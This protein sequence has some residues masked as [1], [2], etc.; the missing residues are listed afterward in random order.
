M[1]DALQ[2]SI[3]SLDIGAWKVVWGPTVWKLDP[4]DTKSAADHIW[5]VASSTD[6][7]DGETATYVVAIAGLAANSG[8]D[9]NEVQKVNEV[10]DFEEFLKDTESP[11]VA[12]PKHSV[13]EQKAYIALG[14]ANGVYRLLNEPSAG[15]ATTLTQFLQMIPSD[16]RVIFTGQS[17]GGLL[18]SALAPTALKAGMLPSVS[19]SN[20]FVYPVSSP[21]PGNRPFADIFAESFPLIV[22]GEKPYQLWNANIWS[23]YDIVPRAW[24]INSVEEQNLLAI[25]TVYGK[26]PTLLH[27]LI[28]ATINLMIDLLVRPSK[29]D[30]VPI[31]GKMVVPEN[32]PPTPQKIEEFMTTAGTQHV[33]TYVEYFGAPVPHSLCKPPSSEEVPMLKLF[34]DARMTVEKSKGGN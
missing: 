16:S 23:K 10:V 27:I 3:D 32:A 5:F 7:V 24:N 15:Q 28:S 18:T 8:V 1:D 21:T 13:D 30:Y 2:S 17:L 6:R 29:I 22:T 33:Q 14:T 25:P 19:P 31:Q 12:T 11:P 4:E 20:V 26:P 9:L 34:N